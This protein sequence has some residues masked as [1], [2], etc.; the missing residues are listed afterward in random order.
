MK[1]GKREREIES[2]FFSLFFSLS[3]SNSGLKREVKKT[4]GGGRLRSRAAAASVSSGEEGQQRRREEGGEEGER[5]NGNGNVGAGDEHETDDADAAV[6]APSTNGAGELDES[7]WRARAE[8]LSAK[9]AK[10]KVSERESIE[11]ERIRNR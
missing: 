4:R 8:A 11:K 3:P 6:A 1:G 10:L 9:N 7:S 2:N 5:A